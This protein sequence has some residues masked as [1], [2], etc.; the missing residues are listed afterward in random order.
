MKKRTL[1]V[2]LGS[3]LIA[4]NVCATPFQNIRIGDVDG[5]GFDADANF[6]SLVGDAG[7][8]V[9]S[10]DRNHDGHLG[11]GDVLPS[12]N[13][14]NVVATGNGDDF[15][16]R[17]AETVGGSGFVDN[18]T[19]GVEYTDIAL[20]TSYDTSQANN[21]VYNANTSS[22]GSGG[23]FPGDANPN[24]LSNQPGFV[25]DFSVA[26]GDINVGDGIFFNM[27]FGDYDVQPATIDFAFAGGTSTLGLSAQ[28]NG[29]ND[30]L[31]QAAFVLLDFSDVFTWDAINNEW[32][33]YVAVDFNAPNEPYTAFD[34]VE[35]SLVAIQADVPEPSS[36]AMLGL[37]LAGL[38]L[39]RRRTKSKE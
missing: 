17:L 22:Y 29:P 7:S 14:N 15:D 10:A 19:T 39:A 34:F 12:L 8:G 16:N 38:G 6:A 37:G 32:D 24:T 9:G 2:T 23:V 31:I 27:L 25:F 3:L 18:G 4:Q 5:F 21:R 26:A 33:G 35:L 36:I 13:G 11:A 20:S 30:G 28:N 1:L